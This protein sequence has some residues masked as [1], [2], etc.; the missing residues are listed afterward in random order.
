MNRAG[1]KMVGKREKEV[2]GKKEK[3]II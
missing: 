3:D 1:K 2:L